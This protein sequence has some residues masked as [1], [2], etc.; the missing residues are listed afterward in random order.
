MS[1]I[2]YMNLSQ[3]Y[4]GFLND[5]TLVWR[6]SSWNLYSWDISAIRFRFSWN[7]EKFSSFIGTLTINI[8]SRVVID[9]L[10]SCGYQE[11]IWILAASSTQNFSNNY[12]SYFFLSL[13]CILAVISECN[14]CFRNYNQE[15]PRLLCLIKANFH[16]WHIK[17]LILDHM[18]LRGRWNL[19]FVVTS[20]VRH[21]EVY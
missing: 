10:M 3:K 16:S 4:I 21:V 14:F 2:T 19:F 12:I 6:F 5:Q 9:F 8:G 13:F 15:T 20:C 11:L 1:T 7:A 18:K 17:L